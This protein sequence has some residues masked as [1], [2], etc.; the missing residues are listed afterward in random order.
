MYVCVGIV[1]FE[2]SSFDIDIDISGGSSPVSSHLISF[3]YPPGVFISFSISFPVSA[4]AISIR[5]RSFGI[6][7]GRSVR[8]YFSSQVAKTRHGAGR[9]TA[10]R[11]Y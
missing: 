11:Y 8:T 5:I 9:A 2:I 6:C 1:R 7:S 4:S 3:S 10:S